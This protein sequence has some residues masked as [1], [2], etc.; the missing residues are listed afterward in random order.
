GDLGNPSKLVTDDCRQGV[1]GRPVLSPQRHDAATPCVARTKRYPVIDRNGPARSARR[2]TLPDRHRQPVAAEP[3]RVARQHPPVDQRAAL[4][5]RAG[6]RRQ[7]HHRL[8]ACGRDRSGAG[9]SLARACRNPTAF[10]AI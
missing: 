6:G 2:R 3:V 1:S 4:C 5:R 8:P 9:C 7:D 10:G